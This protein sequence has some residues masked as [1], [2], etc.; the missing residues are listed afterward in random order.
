MNSSSDCKNK[1]QTQIFNNYAENSINNT[2]CNVYK[3]VS[4]MDGLQN[5]LDKPQNL[6]WSNFET[7]SNWLNPYMKNEKNDKLTN[8]FDFNYKSLTTLDS[9]TSNSLHNLNN[10]YTTSSRLKCNLN[11]NSFYKSLYSNIQPSTNENFSNFLL[12]YADC[13][14]NTTN[15]VSHSLN[16]NKFNEKC[17]NYKTTNDSISQFNLSKLNSKI[18]EPDSPAKDNNEYKSPNFVYPWMKR[19]YNGVGNTTTDP[20]YKRSRTSYTRYQVLELE[21][22]FHYNRYLSRRRR[23]EVAQTLKLTERQIK[24]WFQNRRMKWKKD[25]NLPNSKLTNNNSA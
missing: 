19:A 23:I 9:T 25:H 4:I 22:E 24:I 3:D 2:S 17:I 6:K 13:D 5:N 1:C 10:F 20:N 15:N 12:S 14:K 21:K 16:L 7:N 8:N 11:S 18:V